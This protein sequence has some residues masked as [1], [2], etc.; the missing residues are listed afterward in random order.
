MVAL[1][2]Q[3]KVLNPQASASTPVGTYSV[4]RTE[5]HPGGQAVSDSI[6]WRHRGRS[7]L[8]EVEI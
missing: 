5:P 8:K 6:R 4:R 7:T 3:G 2:A 1:R